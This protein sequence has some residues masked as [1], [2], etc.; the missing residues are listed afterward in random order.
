MCLPLLNVQE[1][2]DIGDPAS[3]LNTPEDNDIASVELPIEANQMLDDS[4][5]DAINA[6][7]AVMKDSDDIKVEEL[8][9]D[10]G[11]PDFRGWKTCILAAFH[12]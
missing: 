10:F 6:A 1:P 7:I 2:V 9:T 5:Q 11:S 8:M 12:S 4:L 3:I